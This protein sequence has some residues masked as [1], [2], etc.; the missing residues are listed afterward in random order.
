[1]KE[2]KDLQKYFKKSDNLADLLTKLLNT[3]DSRLQ[4]IIY[5]KSSQKIRDRTESETQTE[6]SSDDII[7][8]SI[9]S[10]SKLESVDTK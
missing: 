8:S 10:R 5:P 6:A 2:Y 7:D 3:C 4:S 9:E 1:M